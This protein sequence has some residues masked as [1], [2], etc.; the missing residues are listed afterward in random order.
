MNNKQIPQVT[1][2]QA[3]QAKE[4][5]KKRMLNVKIDML[6]VISE[7]KYIKLSQI[8]H[9]QF[10][11]VSERK[12]DMMP[13]SDYIALYNKIYNSD[14]TEFNLI[15]FG[16][17]SDM[18]FVYVQLNHTD[19]EMTVLE[20]LAF[21]KEMEILPITFHTQNQNCQKIADKEIQAKFEKRIIT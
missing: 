12:F 17:I 18:L 16:I 2:E 19:L 3:R 9:N 6:K 10:G 7:E 15:E 4:I 11:I 8:I 21:K 1:D 14:V 13:L 20:Y 5:R